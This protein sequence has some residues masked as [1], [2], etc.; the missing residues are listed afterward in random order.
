MLLATVPCW[1]DL[2]EQVHWNLEAKLFHHRV[3][4]ALYWQSLTGFQLAKKKIFKRLRLNIIVQASKGEFGAE[5]QYIDHGP[6]SIDLKAV[7][8]PRDSDL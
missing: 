2:V 3:P 4:D 6:W 7:S 1:L 8:F 5:R